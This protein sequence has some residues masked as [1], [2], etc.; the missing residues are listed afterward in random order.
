[1]TTFRLPFIHEYRDRHGKLRRYFKRKGGQGIPLPGIPG[2]DE[3]MAAYRAAEAGSV[4]PEIGA[5]RTNPGT[6]SALCVLYYKSVVRAL[7]KAG[8][9]SM[10][11][12]DPTIGISVRIPKTKGHIPWSGEEIQQ[13]RN[14][15]R[16]G[17]QQ[18]LVLEF[19]LEALSR[20]CEVVRLGP[21]HVKDGRIRIERAK[22]SADVDIQLTPE[23]A[24]AIEAMPKEQMVYVTTDTGKPRSVTGLGQNFAK[25]ATQAGL[26]KRCR[27]HGLK[28]SGMIRLVEAGATAHELMAV[29]GHRSLEEA[30]HYTEDFDRKGL[31][32]RA[33]KKRI[34]NA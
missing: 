3:F 6:I 20:R 24:A 8:V 18:R 23:L 34:Q 21:Q 2:S 29:S 27:L 1:M 26:P 5:S 14:Y 19:A 11:L 33:I 28:K 9:P 32:D 30:Q 15:W 7:F 22:G 13:Y 31:A 16:L 25:W 10:R 12:D 4:K 17:T